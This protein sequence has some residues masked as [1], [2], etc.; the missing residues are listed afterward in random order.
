MTYAHLNGEPLALRGLQDHSAG[1]SPPDDVEWSRNLHTIPPCHRN[2]SCIDYPP[3][4]LVY[5]CHF[6]LYS[7]RGP[8][9]YP[10][11]YP[12]VEV[13]PARLHP[14]LVSLALVSTPALSLKLDN[15]ADTLVVRASNTYPTS[16]SSSSVCV[17]RYCPEP[18][19]SSLFER[20][21]GSTSESGATLFCSIKTH[22]S[23]APAASNTLFPNKGELINH[24]IQ[25]HRQ[26]RQAGDPSP[27]PSPRAS[28]EVARRGL[29]RLHL[30]HRLQ[31]WVFEHDYWTQRLTRCQLRAYTRFTGFQRRQRSPVSW[32]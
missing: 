7:A 23:V 17:C 24:S 3:G 19:P 27:F 9:S 6:F 16:C 14:L 2:Y 30:F 10:P 31:L 15:L 29:F 21:A 13:V 1:E 28:P 8:S 22:S 5:A 18:I 4:L 20:G 12:P 26:I 11:D 32:C 25:Y